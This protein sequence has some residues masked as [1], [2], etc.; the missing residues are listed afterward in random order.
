[1]STHSC[2]GALLLPVAHISDF[3]SSQSPGPTQHSTT[4]PPSSGDSRSSNNTHEHPARPPSNAN[5]SNHNNAN[6]RSTRPSSGES[7]SSALP[8]CLT[9][10]ESLHPFDIVTEEDLLIATNRMEAEA[11]DG[12]LE[13]YTACFVRAFPA[14]KRFQNVDE[15]GFTNQNTEIICT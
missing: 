15:L 14:L 6:G 8:E 1:M 7:S 2:D 5:P 13:E 12:D 4:R 9:T 10:A 3:T 11:V